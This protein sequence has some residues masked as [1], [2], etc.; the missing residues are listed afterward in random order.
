LAKKKQP[1]QSARQQGARRGSAAAANEPIVVSGR[2][3]AGALGGALLLALVCAYATLGLLFYQGQ[4][5]L[6]LHPAKTV[7]TTP[8]SK[9]DEIRFDTTETGISQLDGWW[10]PAE[11]EA[12]WAGS[13][14]LYLHGGAGSLSDSVNDLNALHALGVNVFAFDYRGYGKSVGP[15]PNEARMKEDAFAAWRYLSDTRHLDAKSI[16]VYGSGVGASLAADVAASR[17]PAG[18]VLDAP[19][20]PARKIIGAD[21][22]AKILPLW[23]LLTEGFD[24]AEMLKT[25]DV[26]KL[27]LDRDGAKPRTEE[28]YREAASPKDY[29][30][31]HE[32]GYTQTLERFLDGLNLH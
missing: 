7:T 21:A 16:V 10:I 9:F 2:W 12:R 15:H 4:W 27:F 22:R 19:S 30:E 23:L 3:L 1:K 17:A 20:E 31:V 11:P 8:A 14:I 25:L 5:Q 28:L 26:P 18:V 6:I 32:S 24:P 13:T 29:F